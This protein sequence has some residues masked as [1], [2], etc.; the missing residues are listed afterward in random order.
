MQDQYTPETSTNNQLKCKDCGAFLKFAP[1]TNAITC[2]YCGAFNE[3]EKSTEIVEEIDYEKFI[4]EKLS[5]EKQ[6]TIVTVKCAE[7]GAATT[8]KSNITS[9]LCPFCGTS[10]VVAN[11]SASTILKPKSLLPFGITQKQAFELFRLW[12]KKLWFAPNSLRKYVNNT[13]KFNGMYIPYWTYDSDTDSSYTGSRGA[14][15]YVT[16]S[17]T[18]TENGRTVTK[19]RQVRKVRW[20]PVS[21]YVNNAFDDVL[22]TA[23]QSL[24]L[25]YIDKLEPWD[26]KNLIPYD[27]KFLSGFRTECYQVDVKKGFENAKIKMDPVIRFAVKTD[28]GGDEQQIYTLNTTYRNIT[29]KHIL[30]PL[31]ISSY[32]YQNKVYRFMVNAR[33][34]EIHGERPWSVWKI[35]LFSLACILVITG[36]LIIVKMNK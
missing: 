24:P 13:D 35:I 4:T 32:R 25:K 23:S 26:L 20:T 19:T 5:L 30:L 6:Q 27:D 28:I 3:I 17:Y 11:G 9:D 15:Y 18:S 34:G 10:L 29:F 14:Y 31:W 21:G 1:G 33:T 16:E 2:D 8:L 12:I 36:I 22:I 7:C